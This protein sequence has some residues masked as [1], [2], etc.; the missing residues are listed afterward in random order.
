MNLAFHVT[1]IWFWLSGLL[2]GI[3]L[4]SADYKKTRLGVYSCEQSQ[5]EKLTHELNLLTPEGHVQI[6]PFITQF[7][8]VFR[9]VKYQI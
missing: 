7:E 1:N 2:F 4:G 9:E 6:K 5:I 8:I 3:Q